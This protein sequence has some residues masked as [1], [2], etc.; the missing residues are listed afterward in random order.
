MGGRG[1][2]SGT[3]KPTNAVHIENMNE[4]QIDKELSKVDR[5]LTTVQKAMDKIAGTKTYKD[6]MAKYWLGGF[7][8]G[9]GITKAQ[10]KQHEK[11]I[12]KVTENAVKYTKLN[13]EKSTLEQR[14]KSLESAKNQIKGTGKTQAEIAAERKK[15]LIKN[16]KSTMKWETVQKHKYDATGY[17]PKVIKSGEFKISGSNGFYTVYRN[18]AKLGH[19]NKLSEAKAIAERLK[20]KK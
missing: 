19:F 12:N 8:G 20:A 6:D 13:G 1:A 9:S 10:Q 5:R 14:K 3:M 16:T 17:T 11:Y 15:A 7:P 2:S 4:A 18:D